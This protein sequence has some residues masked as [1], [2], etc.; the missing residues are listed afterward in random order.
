[1]RICLQCDNEYETKATYCN[2]CNLDFDDSNSHVIPDKI[3]PEGN[4]VLTKAR[5]LVS[6]IHKVLGS[7]NLI[8]VFAIY[9]DQSHLDNGEVVLLTLISLVGLLHYLA[10]HGLDY[11]KSWGRKLSIFIGFLLLVGFP[12]GTVIGVIVLRQMFRKEWHE[13]DLI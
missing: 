1:M 10:A 3:S 13:A 4:E 8:V 5:K 9:M 12:I 11:K 2:R 6:T 7:I